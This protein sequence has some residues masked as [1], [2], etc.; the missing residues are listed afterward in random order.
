MAFFPS[1]RPLPFLLAI[2]RYQERTDTP[3]ATLIGMRN[4]VTNLWRELIPRS[5]SMGRIRTRLDTES[6]LSYSGAELKWHPLSVDELQQGVI[7][8][9]RSDERGMALV[10]LAM[11]W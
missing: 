4:T 9:G 3:K 6:N 1:K 2:L 10:G 5:T 8:S 7:S 11:E